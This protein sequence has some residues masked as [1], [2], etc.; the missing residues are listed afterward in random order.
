MG[1]K[2]ASTCFS[3]LEVACLDII[4]KVVNRPIVDLLGG[5]MRDAVP[6][7]AYLFYKYEGAGGSLGFGT[8]HKATG[9]DAARQKAAI[10]PE[11]IVAQAHAMCKHYGFQSIK[12]KGGAFPPDQEVAA[13]FALHEAFGDKMPLR[14]DPNAIWKPE[15]ALKYGKKWNLF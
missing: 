13:M 4:G 11:G 6:F 5:K 14:F 7:A 12:L 8:D 15:T 3:A 9:W 10:N 1:S 2:K